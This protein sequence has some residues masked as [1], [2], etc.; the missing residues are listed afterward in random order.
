M[1][2]YFYSVFIYRVKN[3]FYNFFSLLSFTVFKYGNVLYI[4]S[5]AMVRP[6]YV[7][8][9]LIYLFNVLSS[10]FDFIIFDDY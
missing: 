10:Y 2:F 3:Y 1:L 8:I 6:G 4:Y 9:L 7:F 5:N